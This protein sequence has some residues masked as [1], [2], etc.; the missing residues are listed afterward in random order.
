MLEFNI[1][2]WI[3]DIIDSPK[4]WTKIPYSTVEMQNMRVGG[5]DE[6]ANSKEILV[7]PYGIQFR[8]HCGS[9]VRGGINNF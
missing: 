5:A 8:F 6:L 7:Y 3:V 4:P 9:L 2:S 1:F